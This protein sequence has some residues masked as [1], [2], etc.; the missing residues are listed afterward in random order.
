GQR[1][2]QRAAEARGK[3]Q[4]RQGVGRIVVR[5]AGAGGVD[6]QLPEPRESRAA[7]RGGPQRDLRRDPGSD[8]ARGREERRG[9]RL[10]LLFAF[11]LRELVGRHVLE[12][13]LELGGDL[14]F[15]H[16]FALA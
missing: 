11:R 15:V 10:A 3:A 4:G 7:L 5:R 2:G 6:A 12:K 1:G 13:L 14:L 8:E 9:E 16:L